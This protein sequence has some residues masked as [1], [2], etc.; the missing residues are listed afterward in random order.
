M[1][2]KHT[3]ALSCERSPYLLQHAH[4]PV[5]WLP[6]GD[7][8][9]ARARREEKPIFLSVGYSACHWCHVMERESFEDEG[10]ALVLNE[11]FVPVKVDREERPDID[12]VY[13]LAHQL[14]AQRAGGWPLS[15]FL[16]PDGHPFFG[17]TYFPGRPRFGMPSFRELLTAVAEA[18]DTKREALMEQ[19]ARIAEA[20]SRV[21]SV[22]PAARAPTPSL[23]SDALA[24][25][26]PRVDLR[27]GGFGG[28]PKFPNTMSLDL[29]AMAAAMALPEH[30]DKA[31]EGLR[32]TLTKM[33]EGGIW[34]HL[35]GGFA[36]YSTDGDWKVPHFEKMLYDNGLLLRLYVDGARVARVR[37]EAEV[38]ARFERVAADVV[39]YL[40]REMTSPEGVFYS[41]QDADSEGEEGRFFAWTLD[42]LEA[43]LSREDARVVAAY[44]DVSAEG[45]WEHSRNVLWTPRPLSEVAASL[46]MTADAVREVIDRAQPILF[47]AREARPKP[48]R[49][50]KC[51]AG[52]NA[53]VIG[54]LAD[55]GA[56]LHQPA[57]IDAA[58][59]A[60][61]A[62][63]DRAWQTDR[64]LH[65]MKDGEAYGA[66]YCDDHAG[67]GC[68]ALDVWEA[69]FDAAALAFA[70]DLA[71]A[72]LA[73]FVDAATGE[74]F[75]VSSDAEVVLHRSRDPFDHAQPGAAGLAVEL[76]ARLGAITGEARYRDAA[77]RAAGRYASA[78]VDN[79]IGLASVV[80][81][82]DR[83]VRGAVEVIVTGDVEDERTRAR[84]HAARG[85]YLPHRV[86]IAAKQGDP[87]VDPELL[88]GRSPAPDGAPRAFVCRGTA[89]EMPVTTREAL[90]ETL[91]RAVREHA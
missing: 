18:W 83:V 53:L 37:G 82:V 81:A 63:R 68:A 49:D 70:R 40:L 5:D 36:R 66:G 20:V 45:N 64:L 80:R 78:A 58:R 15:M 87:N 30:G 13:Q 85:R 89:C 10:T 77:E 22:A 11:L 19:G 34:D 31:W 51:L 12:Q 88:V 61:S 47:A 57:W 21:G 86:L 90:V 4:N 52:W 25:V 14:I 76:L 42:E 74:F 23:L 84:L 48:L 1:S 46:S 44:F 43:P 26:L 2:H 54:A 7:E 38:A 50:D 17:G 71:D 75:F 79:P 32:A 29:L 24:K 69:T 33:R 73:R 16:T 35:G 3:N 62:W 59:R 9:I 8:A 6:W 91:D 56:T 28:A 67:M 27:M 65:A 41:A 60:L 72:V 39:T 55:A